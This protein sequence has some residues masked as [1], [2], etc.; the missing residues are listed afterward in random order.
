MPCLDNTRAVAWL[1]VSLFLTAF[2]NTIDREHQSWVKSLLVT[3]Q[4][5][6]PYRKMGRMQVLYSF[7]F[8]DFQNSWQDV[9]QLVFW[10]TT[11]WHVIKWV[12]DDKLQ[13]VKWQSWV[14]FW[15]TVYVNT[16]IR[17]Y[18]DYA[19]SQQE[20]TDIK[21]LTLYSLRRKI[22]STKCATLEFSHVKYL[23]TSH[24]WSW[25]SINNRITQEM[26][27][28]LWE[29]LWVTCVISQIHD[30]FEV[31]NHMQQLKP[32]IVIHIHTEYQH[33]KIP[34]SETYI[35]HRVQYT[36]CH[37]THGGWRQ[38]IYRQVERMTSFPMTNDS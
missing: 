28:M 26:G 7:S 12:T 38:A 32:V 8:T 13:L 17:M 18:L 3:A 21:I 24:I 25:N 16:K 23:I 37:T 4:Q 36:K 9:K 6:E 2:T 10:L 19:F 5:S 1:S 15:D 34:H 11:V 27:V 31:I 14:I 20:T 35:I 22:C 30:V 29:S 33:L